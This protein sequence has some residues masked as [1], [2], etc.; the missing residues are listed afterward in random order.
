ME[1]K[2]ESVYK[3]YLTGMTNKEKK[4]LQVFTIFFF[5]YLV[6]F[7]FICTKTQHFLSS[8]RVCGEKNCPNIVHFHILR[9]VK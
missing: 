2:T 8:K 6:A 3:K 7:V 4:S 1:T 5:F 9:C